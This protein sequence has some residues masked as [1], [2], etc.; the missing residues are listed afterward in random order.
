MLK[1][2]H[3]VRCGRKAMGLLLDRQVAHFST[4]YLLFQTISN[5]K[6][7]ILKRV[8][9]ML[10][11]A[12]F[13]VVVSGCGS[14]GGGSQE[15]STS[16]LSDNGQLQESN[17][18]QDTTDESQNEENEEIVTSVFKIPQIDDVQKRDFLDA[19]NDARSHVQDCGVNGMMGPV[20]P[21]NWDEKLYQA[22][23]EHS[24]DMAHS[25][26]FSHTGSG[27]EYDNIAVQSE[28]GEGSTMA[29]RVEF[30]GYE[31][32]DLGENI[33]AGQSTLEVVIEGWIDSDGHCANLMSE[34]FTEMG[35]ALYEIKEGYR[36]YWTQNF[37][38]TF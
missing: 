1:A 3:I 27:T 26:H 25:G 18:I 6:E 14:S 9:I 37:G 4:M 15:E 35:M 34:S 13:S 20:S 33:A 36:F 5:V 17:N 22:A 12:V 38:D 31:W 19:V 16:S 8:W 21:L 24:Y 32:S 30:Y 28:L 11:A 23:Y 2:K 10:F 7:H 29:D